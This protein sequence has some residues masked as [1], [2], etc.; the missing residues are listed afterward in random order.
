VRVDASDAVKWVVAVVGMLSVSLVA[1]TTALDEAR[2][3]THTPP[4]SR[5]G[6]GLR[7]GSV[8]KLYR[9]LVLQAGS[10][11]AAAPPS[12]IAAQIQQESGWNPNAISPAGAEG[13]SQFLPSTWPHWSQP[14]QSPFDPEAAIAAQGSYDCA[15]AETMSRAQTQGRLSKSIDLTSLM[16]AGYNAGPAA[17]LSAHGIPQNGQTPVYV[18]SILDSAPDFAG[19]TDTLSGAGTFAAREI[20]A[21][22]KYLGTP[23]AWAGGDFLGPTRGQCAGGAAINDCD[24]VGFDCSGLVLYAVYV[25]SRGAIRLSHSA[26][27]QTRHGTPVPIGRLQPGDLISFSDPGA[28]VAHHVGIYLGNDQLLNAPESNENVRIDSLATP[29]YRDQQWR[30]VRY[31]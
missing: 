2:E 10:Q 7:P 6:G 29:Y 20:A 26:D 25:A 19:A 4:I 12:V 13:I 22:Q 31:G 24:K 15:I 17:A 5:T 28:S 11:C 1:M 30:A 3:A 23:Y 9:N 18:R 21:A 8:P 14:G 16:L 27:E